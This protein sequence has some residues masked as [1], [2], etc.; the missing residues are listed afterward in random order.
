MS[1][2]EALVN[3][4][5][6]GKVN[7]SVL[8][9]YTIDKTAAGDLA[10]AFEESLKDEH[11]ATEQE[12][13]LEMKRKDKPVLLHNPSAL[14]SKSQLAQPLAIPLDGSVSQFE[15]DVTDLVM[16]LSKAAAAGGENIMAT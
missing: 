15:K 16:G 6:S 14:A 3:A 1:I 12:E 7:A 10:R 4:A 5:T 13:I 2:N 11:D 8:P 9:D